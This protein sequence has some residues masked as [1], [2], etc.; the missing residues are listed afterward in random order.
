MNARD[1]GGKSPR[2]SRIVFSLLAVFVF[3]GLAPL[4]AVAWK[5]IDLNREALTTA[6]QEFQL[7][8][9][10]SI[11]D[12]LDIH[13][14]NL[15][16]QLVVLARTLG[17]SVTVDGSERALDLRTVLEDATDGR[18]VF[19]QY[20]ATDARG[21]RS[22]SAGSLPEGFE[23]AFRVALEQA[24][25]Q[26]A[27]PGAGPAAGA[28]VTAPL[29]PDREPLTPALVISAPVVSGGRFRGV[30]SVMV[31]LQEVWNTVVAQNRTGHAVFAV[32]R[33]ARVI[34]STDV[35][36]IAPGSDVS[37]SALA[38]RF[39]SSEGR[40][41]E[42]L[43]YVDLSGDTEQ[44]Y[45]A[46]YVTTG[47]GWGVFVRA[48]QREV[49]LP[50]QAMTEGTINWSLAVLGLAA[51]LALFFARTLSNPIN[52]LA[53]ASSAFARGDFS[54]RAEVTSGNEIGLLAETFNTMA[55]QIES[56]IGRLRKAA[57]ENNELFLGTIR[58]LA[59]AID[60]KDP[61]TRGHS[62]RVNRYSVIIAQTM[63]LSRKEIRD[64]HVA[65]LLHDVGKIGINEAVLNK[66]GKLTDEEFALIKTHP[67]LGANIM[68]PIK[69]MESIIPGLRWHHER[70]GG[71]GY[72]DGLKGEE[73]PLMARIIAV[74]DTF[75]AITTCRPYQATMPIDE[76]FE[77]IRRLTGPNLEESVVAAFF[78]AFAAGR[79]CLD[80]A[81]APGAQIP[82][83]VAVG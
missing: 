33:T 48:K 4:A 51:L 58:A 44:S 62:V 11:A 46:S 34:A 64:I 21:G 38:Q 66:P 27:V 67:V 78:A 16:Y 37:D 57:E 73:I 45:L 6:Q 52:R 75:D 35:A 82:Q 60:A 23:V 24:V 63:N 70:W 2:R 28:I 30:L 69:Q 40:T 74:A 65:S 9:A 43:P 56:H 25:Q 42:T 68:S 19:I 22:I 13:V 20:S 61:Y 59:Q 32:D 7:L 12:E 53:A 54:A 39:L 31:D 55:D 1:G 15:R 81:D 80:P 18:L 26:L 5:L 8:L 14:E 41:R 36:R 79:I 47:Q 72:P 83:A 76:A 50:V 29:L 77:T 17:A 3:V 10:S 71:G 49:Y